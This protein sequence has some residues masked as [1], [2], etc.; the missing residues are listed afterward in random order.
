MRVKLESNHPIGTSEGFR[1]FDGKERDL[2]GGE[3]SDLKRLGALVSRWTGIQMD[4]QP[5][6]SRCINGV[7]H[8]FPKKRVVGVHCIRVVPTGE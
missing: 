6:A 1:P 3:Y 7:P 2:H 8:F 5:G 4:Y